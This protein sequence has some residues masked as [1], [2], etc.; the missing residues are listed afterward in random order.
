MTD[1]TKRYKLPPKAKKPHGRP[2]LRRKESEMQT[3]VCNYIRLQYPG[4]VFISEA[5]GEYRGWRAA[6]TAKQQRSSRGLPD[7]I[8]LAARN[9]Y[10][11]LCIELKADGERV[12][13]EDGTPASTHIAE[14]QAVLDGLEAGGYWAGFVVGFDM[15]KD[16]IDNYMQGK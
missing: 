12:F 11:G 4:T 10:H 3:A 15:A 16:V 6:K 5:A 14:Q 8:V 7:L 9:G 2:P 13:K 1:K